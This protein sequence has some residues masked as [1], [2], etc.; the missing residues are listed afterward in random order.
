[1]Y[2]PK[3]Q[4]LFKRDPG[5]KFVIMPG[6]YSREE[7]TNVK[8]W[9]FTEKI[10]GMNMQVSYKDD[11]LYYGPAFTFQG[12]TL[13]AEIPA[14]LLSFM[15]KTFIM[16]R[17]ENK[18][19]GAKEVTLIGEGYGAGI[20]KGGLYQEAKEFILFDVVIDG[21]WLLRPSVEDIAAYF[22]V[23]CVPEIYW[24][25]TMSDA[26]DYVKSGPNSIIAHGVKQ[27]EGIVAR[28]DPL[29]LFRNGN[30]LMWKLKIRDFE[31][32]ET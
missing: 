17:I 11:S 19:D 10:D 3:M 16:E 24:I 20:Q 15:Q 23:D 4:T 21:M 1:M 29:M 6:E 31:D 25:K 18:F 7:F 5:N 13:K 32:L 14:E 9:N 30:P 26:V 8:K 2:Y 28:S 27:M 22:K 12:R